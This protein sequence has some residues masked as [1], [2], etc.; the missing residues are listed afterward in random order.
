MNALS[1]LVHALAK[2]ETANQKCRPKDHADL[3]RA[4][5]H[6]HTAM[7]HVQAAI[8]ITSDYNYK[9]LHPQKK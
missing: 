7:I 8:G 1:Y 3:Q 5:A 6:L 9:V 4:H 2:L